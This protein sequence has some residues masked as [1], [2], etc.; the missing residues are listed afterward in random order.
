M[1]KKTRKILKACYHARIINTEIC[2]LCPPLFYIYYYFFN[3]F[4]L[5]LKTKKNTDVLYN[6]YV[7][8]NQSSKP[9]KRTESKFCVILRC[10]TMHG[11]TSKL[12]QWMV[13]TLNLTNHD[14][15]I[16]HSVQ[17]PRCMIGRALLRRKVALVPS[18]REITP[19]RFSL[20][21]LIRCS[22]IDVACIDRTYWN[23]VTGL[24]KSNDE[25]REES[26]WTASIASTKR[27]NLR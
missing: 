22:R 11:R 6:Q 8:Y 17:H 1:K 12:L 4:I 23:L 16:R 10:G 21:K 5:A 14:K 9:I 2:P 25:E 27:K 19:P 18:W 15:Y 20:H 13:A 3:I 24:D 26:N 7:L